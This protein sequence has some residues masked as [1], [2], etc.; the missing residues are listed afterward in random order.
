MKQL[1][2]NARLSKKQKFVRTPQN[3]KLEVN[4]TGIAHD[5]ISSL[6]VDNDLIKFRTSLLGENLDNI[7]FKYLQTSKLVSPDLV[8]R[9]GTSE[10]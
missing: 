7:P 8:A 9:T 3:F 5:N 4:Q 10:L 1:C 2:H 6:F